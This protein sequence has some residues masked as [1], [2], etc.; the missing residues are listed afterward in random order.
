MRIFA[1]IAF[2]FVAASTDVARADETADK[3]RP[4]PL[5]RPDIKV[6]LEEMK[7]RKPRIPLPELTAEEKAKFDERGSGYEARL[8]Y[9]Y[10][11]DGGSGFGGGFAREADP[12]MTLENRFKVELFWLVSRI[13]NCHY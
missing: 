3:P 11:P 10:M 7:E 5:T 8:R 9:H 2:G 6:L 4:V 12:N 13:N 1:L